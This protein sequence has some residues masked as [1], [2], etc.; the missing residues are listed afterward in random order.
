MNE[1]EWPGQYEQEGPDEA[2]GQL[3]RGHI[4]WVHSTARR[5]VRDE[6]LAE[7]VTQA[8]FVTL[9]RKAKDMKDRP[10]PPWLLRVTRYASGHALRAEARRKH[11]EQD[12]DTGTQL[13]DNDTGTQL[14]DMGQ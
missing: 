9:V 7:D 1:R 3:V 13:V 2:L 11:H 14:V 4:D 6:H 8:V 5:Q 10:L 12:N